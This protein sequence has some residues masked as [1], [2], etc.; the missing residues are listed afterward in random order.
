MGAAV[1][2]GA[3]AAHEVFPTAGSSSADR[4]VM[5]VVLVTLGVAIY[6]VALRALGIV[7]LRE[8]LAGMRA[9]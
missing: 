6:A 4:L 8:L 9:R 1:V 2:L 7:T 5:L 3:V